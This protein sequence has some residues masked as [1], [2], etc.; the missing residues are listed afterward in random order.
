MASRLNL[1]HEKNRSNPNQRD[2]DFLQDMH[3]RA[4]ELYAELQ[5]APTPR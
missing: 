1:A 3:E 2:L 5:A 4:K